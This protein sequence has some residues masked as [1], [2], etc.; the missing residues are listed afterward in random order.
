M[1]NFNIL[2]AC[3]VALCGA[4]HG[5]E[6]VKPLTI[7]EMP[8]EVRKDVERAMADAEKARTAYLAA[9]QKANA[10][11]IG[12][13]EKQVSSLTRRGNLEGALAAQRVVD[14][15]KAGWIRSEI[16][17][18]ID[19]FGDVILSNDIV[20]RSVIGK[21]LMWKNIERLILNS[22]GTVTN[23]WNHNWTWKIVD[24]NIVLTTRDQH[25]I[26]DRIYIKNNDNI[27]VCPGFGQLDAK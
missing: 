12:R 4:C 8:A 23:P 9:L 7:E 19:I 1:R 22:D 17:A 11:A 14:Q 27:Y 24:Y 21:V 26:N 13:M 2:S 10:D 5:A 3:L 16:E 15:L 6:E 18:D 20:R 25:G